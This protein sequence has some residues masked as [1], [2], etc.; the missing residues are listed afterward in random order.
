MQSS[1]S[2]PSRETWRPH[3]STTLSVPAFTTSDPE[4]WFARL[5]LFF[6]HR[7]ILDEATK[8]ELALS[9]MPEESLSQLRDF[10]LTADR[11]AAPYTA[12][13]AISLQRLVDSTENRI[14][15]ALTGEDLA[16]HTPSALLHR[17]YQLLPT[18]TVEREDPILRQLF[19]TRLPRQ[20]QAALLPFGD[21]PLCELARLG[22]SLMALQAPS[23]VMS[24]YGVQDT[25][26]RLDRLEHM[27]E[28]LTLRFDVDPHCT[29]GRSPTARRHQTSRSPSPR[30][31]R[32][33]TRRLCFYHNRFGQNA[34]KCT[35]P[36]EAG[37]RPRRTTL[38]AVAAAVNISRCTYLMDRHSGTRFLVDTG[39]AISLL[40]L[41]H[42]IDYPTKTV[43]QALQAINGTSVK[44]S[45]AKTLTV[46]FDNMPPLTWTFTVAKIDTPII[47]ADLIHHHQLIV[48]LANDRVF[49]FAQRPGNN[50]SP[51]LAA[52]VSA[53]P[54]KFAQLLQSFVD[55][56]HHYG[57]NTE[58]K[59]NSLEHIQHVIETTGPP[60]YSKPRR[61]APER[62]RIAKQHF[63]DLLR[64]GIVRPSNSNWSSSLHLVPKQ[65]PGQWRP[66]GDFRNLNRY[67]K[68]DRYPL[69]QIADFNN[70]LR[71]KTIFSK[72]DLAR[73]YFQ[74][75]VRPQDVPKTAITTPF[76]LFE[77]VMMPFGLRNA[78]QTFQRFIDQV[79]RGL[80]NCFAYVDDILLASRSESEH[81]EL[82][83][84]LFDRLATFGLK[85]NP[86]KCV[87]GAES[88]VFLGHLVDCKGIQP[89]PEKVAAI[90]L[91]P[92][93][94][95]VK[96]LRQFLGMVNFY[97]RFSPNLAVTLRPLDALVAKATNNILWPQDAVNAFNEAKST[98]SNATLL[99]HPKPTA[100]LA[101]MVDAS[102][103]AM[104]AVL[105]QLV[106]STWRPLAFFS[107]RLQDHQKRYSTFGREL[108]AVYAAVK[109]F[110]SEI[111]G[112]ELMVFT[113]HKPLVR[114]FEN[115][116][117][118]LNDREIRQLDFIT[119]MQTQ[120]KHISG[121][122]NVVADAL[123]RKIYAVT[124]GTITL[125]AKEIAVA[126]SKDTELQ[127]VKDHTSLQLIPEPV[128]GCAHPLWKDMS[129]TEAR[130]YVPATL[131]LAFFRSVHGLSHPGVRA[132]KRVMLARYV[133]PSIQKDVAQWT[134]CCL[135]CQQAKVYR[136]TRSVPKEFPL[137]STRFDHVHVDIVGP[138]PPS[139]GF[140]YLL[141]AVDRFS[142]WP[143]AWPIRDISA[144][145]VAET[146]LS[147]WIARFGV[148]RQIT[149]DRGRQFESHMWM[150]LNKLLG[151][152]HIPTSAY[153]PQANG[154]VERLHRQLK[155]ALIARMQ[156][157][158][159]KWTT[160]L[161][162]V[163]LGI[164][165]AVK[166]D[167]GLAPAETLYGSTLRLPAE[168]LA[169]AVLPAS[170]VDPTSFTSILKAV[171]HRL[172]PTPPRRNSTATF[173][174][175]ALRDCSHVFIR[176]PGLT[177]S[178]TPPYAGPYPVVRRT[179]KTVTIDAGG[180][181]TTVAIDRTKPAF[182]INEVQL[183]SATSLRQVKFRWP[184]SS[185]PVF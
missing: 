122:D 182:M 26:Q 158:N 136:H 99:E 24:A 29:R 78:A 96:Q 75:P 23:P 49:P 110:R 30:N 164:R 60:V 74:I 85:V 160:A 16:D 109:H 150:A 121:R 33:N 124:D 120:I 86:E 130:I 154:L 111:E 140:R 144:Q 108:L 165:T 41:S 11:H 4:L 103:Q 172:R 31:D 20:L 143:E 169:P 63:D 62:L 153:H 94:K 173:V 105:Q 151:I 180:S 82:L 104:G 152:Q 131:R 102:D 34:R 54:D 27:L 3:V 56:Q 181:E 101:L 8:F 6:Q 14:R 171:M 159:I 88:L 162:L 97:R 127:W 134:R 15:Q 69:P 139:D 142:R 114:A 9:A 100:M 129:T 166:A 35:P 32:A 183:S 46:H 135:H 116:S 175:G 107:K 80:D 125:S 52:S 176:E 133:W 76:G 12:F 28:Q 44:V 184:P 138:L 38:T 71:G 22:D 179:D 112:R 45:G 137:P 149:T 185:A 58:Q 163:L 87:L 115:G 55:A 89:S 47:G 13:K 73:A 36:C 155:A 7:H 17:L 177:G 92:R 156:A 61:L 66:C 157:V 98:L 168:F 148:P 10:I 57:P 146:F 93:P 84:K 2:C 19:L 77:F 91:F 145:T 18:S 106:G 42:G 117:Q 51:G 25:T 68:P 128:E 113:D 65:Q 5:Q 132:T 174:S 72:I 90:K 141:T 178:L 50:T 40:P 167:I 126:Q 83:R 37:K 118:G 161:P 1:D 81:L 53:Q 39:A 43:T 67:T 70:D 147:N 79:L 119:S 95:T 123:S 170:N 21:K 59:R 48:D 64:Q